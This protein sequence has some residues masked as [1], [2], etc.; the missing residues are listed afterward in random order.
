MDSGSDEQWYSSPR[1]VTHIDDNAISLLREYYEA[2]LPASGRV[3]D[4]CSSWISHFPRNLETRATRT[5]RGEAEA[6]ESLE[7][8]GAGLNQ[9]ELQ[10]NPILKERVVQDLNT[11]PKLPE[12]IGILD[13]ATC[14][15]S[16][17]Y[18]IHP[19]Q[20]LSSIWDHLKEGG[21]THLIISNRCFPTK[22]IG[23]WLQISED[24]RLQMAADY[25]WFAGYR[26]I[27]I[28]TL[29]DGTGD[30]GGW[31][32]SRPD[33]LWVVRGKKIANNSP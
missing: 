11:N 5:A 23:R 20:T 15:V 7:V 6:G 14:V 31:F 9:A 29:C 12:S 13:A 3:F 21:S 27:E 26:E 18:L 24:E 19:V 2:A 17:D 22:V 32:S 1:F 30:G 16:I 10:G 8:I 33:P 4:F 25:L 28:L